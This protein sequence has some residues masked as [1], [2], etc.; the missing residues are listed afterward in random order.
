MTAPMP[1]T[2]AALPPRLLP[3][4]YFGTAHL[5]FLL[6][7]AAVAWHP[8]AILGFYYH[9]WMLG[10][11]HLVT[12]GW[13]TTSILGALY[14]AGPVAL[15]M[16]VAATPLDYAAFACVLAGTAGMVAHFWIEEYSGMGWSGAI[17]AAGI[18]IVGWRTWG[19]LRGAGLPGAVRAHLACAFG[20]V[21]VAATT[22]VLL[23]F[24]KTQH[25]LP[26]F[27][28]ATVTAHAHLAAIGWA[29]MMVVGV[30]YRLFPMVLP[31]Q[32]PAGPRLWWTA[33]LLEGGVL[34]LYVTLLARGRARGLF[35][36]VIVAAVAV[37][38]AHVRWMR[39]HPRP[40][41]PA[42]RTPDPAVL[43]AGAALLSWALAAGLGLWLAFAPT[44]P[45]T[46]R[47]ALAYGVFGLVGFLA[48]LVVG[49]S[50]RLLPMLAWYWAFAATGFRGPVV[51]PFDMPIRPLQL[52]G[53]ALWW[54]G[55]P[56]LASGLVAEHVALVRAGAVA[57]G[58]AT[59]L[60]S[61]NLWRLARFAWAP[62]VQA[63]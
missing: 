39:A 13:I 15:R 58:T 56:A 23:A 20:N 48:Q 26:G 14:V 51:A 59:A 38:F 63:R 53:V 7:C 54:I 11:V 28:L 29:T 3:F 40:R 8:R 22:G 62:C 17:G 16:R 43:H 25:F 12:L 4:L 35:A 2:T 33:V 30:G 34:G 55:V 1:A 47:V 21:A 42:I 49:M 50:A 36:A 37:F 46:L 60:G 57:L 27:S 61:V 10:L 44:T 24:D 19:A 45:T 6:A 52:A 18:L 9:P 32:M 31:S 41:P 5:A